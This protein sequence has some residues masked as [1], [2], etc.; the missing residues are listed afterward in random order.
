MIILVLHILTVVAIIDKR[1]GLQELAS[2]QLDPQLIFHAALIPISFCLVP[3]GMRAAWIAP[4]AAGMIL[5]QRSLLQQKLLCMLVIY[6]NGKCP[7]KHSLCMELGF[8]SIADDMI[9]FVNDQELVHFISTLSQPQ[10]RL[11]L[12]WHDTIRSIVIDKYYDIVYH[13]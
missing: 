12:F 2:G 3:V 1:S 6:E 5:A 4:Q 7:M 11:F 9:F 13:K 8:L 10:I